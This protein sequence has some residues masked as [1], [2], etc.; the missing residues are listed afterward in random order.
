M[1]ILLVASA[2]CIETYAGESRPYFER[3]RSDSRSCCSLVPKA[4]TVIDGESLADSYLG[5][6][7]CSRGAI[8]MRAVLVVDDGSERNPRTAKAN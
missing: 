5:V 4:G 1:W 8:D 2:Y 3:C 7:D 6:C